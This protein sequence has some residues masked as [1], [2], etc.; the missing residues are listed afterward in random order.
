MTNVFSI[1]KGTYGLPVE[2]FEVEYVLDEHIFEFNDMWKK[3]KDFDPTKVQTVHGKLWVPR[4]IVLLLT[5]GFNPGAISFLANKETSIGISA[6]KSFSKLNLE[7]AQ[8]N[9]PPEDVNQSILDLQTFL[10]LVEE[11]HKILLEKDVEEEFESLTLVF[12][13]LDIEERVFNSDN[14]ASFGESLTNRT[15]VLLGL[16]ED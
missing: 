2:N 4:K 8:D 1:F 16:S 6:L 9:P 13:V 11:E 14:M 12:E 15:T 3:P 5:T 7:E 10:S